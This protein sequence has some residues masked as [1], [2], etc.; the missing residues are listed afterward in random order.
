MNRLKI[1]L[2]VKR[3]RREFEPSIKHWGD[4]ALFIP[5][6]DFKVDHSE[7][8]IIAHMPCT[9]VS[10]TTDNQVLFTDSGNSSSV[11]CIHNVNS[12][13]QSNKQ[14]ATVVI[15]PRIELEH[16]LGITHVDSKLKLSDTSSTDSNDCLIHKHVLFALEHIFYYP[17]AT[18]VQYKVIPIL[19]HYG[20]S[21]IVEAPTGSGKTLAFLIPLVERILSILSHNEM[22][23]I[24]HNKQVDVAVA[25]QP[26]LKLPA[27]PMRNRCIVGI[28][29][30]PLSVLAEQSYN[31][32]RLLCARHPGNIQHAL[33]IHPGHTNPTNIAPDDEIDEE[34]YASCMNE[35]FLHLTR[36]PRGP[37]TI[38]VTTPE[39]LGPLCQLIK[40]HNKYLNSNES[41]PM[42]SNTLCITGQPYYPLSSQCIETPRTMY[43][44][45]TFIID[46]AD[47][48]IR[49]RTQCDMIINFCS[50]LSTMHSETQ[51]IDL[52]LFGATVQS[53]GPSMRQFLAKIPNL[54]RTELNLSVLQVITTLGS[55][56]EIRIRHFYH[57][58]YHPMPTYFAK[59]DIVVDLQQYACLGLH[60]KSMELIKLY[61]NPY[62]VKYIESL[63]YILNKH[64]TQK[65]FLFFS[66]IS[67]LKFVHRLLHLL[68]HP[69]ENQSAYNS[70][71]NR[72]LK[73]TNIFVFHEQ[74][75]DTDRMRHF[76]Q[77]IHYSLDTCPTKRPRCD[78]S[79][80]KTKSH[81]SS[82]QMSYI[83]NRHAKIENLNKQNSKGAILL[84]TDIAA[85][86][87]DVSQ[88]EY[89]IHVEL[90]SNA[91]L[92]KN[93][94]HSAPSL[95]SIASTVYKHRSGRVARMG[96]TGSSIILAHV[97]K[98]VNAEIDS[99]DTQLNDLQEKLD[100]IIEKYKVHTNEPS[101]TAIIK[102]IM[103]C[104]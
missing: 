70:Y 42:N 25:T 86:G 63:V 75:S 24:A 32:A 68:S 44:P 57:P 37:G 61:C 100:V 53:A 94:D 41:A 23:V 78:S 104:I 50:D 93:T 18:I 34:A 13:E 73:T 81:K 84:C 80:T 17:H 14:G 66:S 58:V 33:Y 20:V 5:W 27:L 36:L 49:S 10:N 28:V 11:Y 69:D 31:I 67:Q 4:T 2:D 47:I 82:V 91:E 65:H 101:I 26:N 98:P 71:E 72:V 35:M 95:A 103:K 83:Q 22:Y 9:H 92:L 90:V 74:L 56:F 7:P 59:R 85:Y 99:P 51:W 54:T 30:A 89:V 12:E 21:A 76:S 6:R 52:H 3:I 87:I 77:F 102:N 48:I 39:S 88:V 64:P 97:F 43:T 8:C 1:D 29:V 38:V 19:R 46:E 15:Y 62:N 40:V 55:N 96:L 79:K 45:V 60:S 16:K